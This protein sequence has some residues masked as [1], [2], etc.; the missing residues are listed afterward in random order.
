MFCSLAHLNNNQLSYY[1]ILI[2]WPCVRGIST[3]AYMF[4]KRLCIMFILPFSNGQKLIAHRH[5]RTIRCNYDWR[6]TALYAENFVLLYLLSEG[7]SK[8]SG[9]STMDKIKECTVFPI[10]RIKYFRYFKPEKVQNIS[11]T[12]VKPEP[13]IV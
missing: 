6:A 8:K 2:Y 4:L 3:C 11:Y 7:L 13:T 10:Y 12:I 5:M 1:L 9:L